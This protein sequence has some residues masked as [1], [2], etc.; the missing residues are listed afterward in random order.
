[1]TDHAISD[2]YLQNGDD[3]LEFRD[4]VTEACLLVHADGTNH[5]WFS[6]EHIGEVRDWCNEWLEL[7]ATLVIGGAE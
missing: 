7:H 1:M 6:P 4:G 3:D 2:L 5:I